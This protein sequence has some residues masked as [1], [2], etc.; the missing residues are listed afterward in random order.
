MVDNPGK[1]VTKLSFSSLFSQAWYMAIKP[2]T[3]IAGFG[4]VGACPFDR[5]VI[6]LLVQQNVERMTV[7]GTQKLK[8]RKRRH[9]KEEEKTKTKI[10]RMVRNMK[11]PWNIFISL[12]NK[13]NTGSLMD[14]TCSLLMIIEPPT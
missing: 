9:W 1:V 8:L 11:K 7:E 5:S 13:L 12:K 2:E 3:I 4:K 14:M 10:R 6:S